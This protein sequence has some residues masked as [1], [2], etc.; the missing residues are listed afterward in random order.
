MQE[1]KDD[2]YGCLNINGYRKLN[3]PVPLA[4]ELLSFISELCINYTFE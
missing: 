3:I 4:Q 2:V 1:K